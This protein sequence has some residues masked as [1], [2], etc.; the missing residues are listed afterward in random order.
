MTPLA[1]PASAYQWPSLNQIGPGSLP[2]WLSASPNTDVTGIGMTGMV[3]PEEFSP[4]GM[5]KTNSQAMGPLGIANAALGG[6][7]TIGNIWSAWQAN[8]LAK[9]QF[10]LTKNLSETNLLNSIKSYNTA[11]FDRAR[12]RA[13]MEGQTDAERDAY[14]RDHSLSRAGGG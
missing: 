11:L 6:L 13:A 3:T 9:K 14:I 5:G 2:D 4:M 8:K 12:S 10:K 7:Q 1:V